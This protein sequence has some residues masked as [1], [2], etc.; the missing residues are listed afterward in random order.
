[1]AKRRARILRLQDYSKA[2]RAGWEE[3]D[4]Y[5]AIVHEVPRLFHSLD[6]QQRHEALLERPALTGTRWDA[7]LAATVEH[8]AE[9]HGLAA[10]AWTTERERFLDVP[11]VVSRNPLIRMQSIAFAPPAFIRHGALPDPRDL[12]AR[13]GEWHAWVP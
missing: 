8:V 10:P 2:I 6:R 13:G 1:M 4:L 9:L 7:L 11:W 5:R 3:T 12:D